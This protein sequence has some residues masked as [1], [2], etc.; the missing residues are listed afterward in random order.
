M[1]R[2]ILDRLIYNDEYKKIDTNLTDSN[3]GARKERNI[4]DNI[5]VMNAIINSSRKENK[6]ALDCQ[7]FDIEKCFDSLWLNEVINCL[8]EAGLNNDKL[9]LIFM[10]NSNA[11]VAV[12]S[13]EGIS[14]R[15][16]IKILSCRDRSGAV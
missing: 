6:E 9:P 16:N 15:V 5:F 8:Y 11:K 2:S 7:V 1:F 13:G 3:V 12:K 14:S 4:R 10:E